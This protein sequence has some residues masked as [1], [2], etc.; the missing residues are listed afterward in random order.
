MKKK[1]GLFL[2]GALAVAA[3]PTGANYFSNA[4]IEERS[5][6]L[7]AKM[8]KVKVANEGLGS[9]GNHSMSVVHREGN[10]EAEFH[11]TQSDII[12]I[13]GGEASIIIGGTI[14]DGKKTTA[15]EIRG[16]KIDGGQKESL[17]AG[18]V[19]HIPIKTPHQ[20]L[21]RPGQKLDYLAIKVD[22]R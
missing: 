20:M 3:L 6:A 13:R 7:P 14:P 11:E 19:L 17:H 10:G 21:L 22:A 8:G 4:H 1:I 5:K 12:I 18:D 9:W 2:L 16:S 15:N